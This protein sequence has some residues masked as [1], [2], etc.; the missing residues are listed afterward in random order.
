VGVILKTK[1]VVIIDAIQPSWALTK[2]Y[3]WSAFINITQIQVARNLTVI[4]NV[5][6]YSR[7]CRL[8]HIINHLPAL[9]LVAKFVAHNE[10]ILC[11]QDHSSLSY[12]VRMITFEKG[13][14]PHMKDVFRAKVPTI[15]HLSP[16]GQRLGSLRITPPYD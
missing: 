9:R 3:F 5:L 12:A 4:V 2:S 7:F 13:V 16:S 11:R 1:Q 10:P 8:I 14:I 15:W 6:A